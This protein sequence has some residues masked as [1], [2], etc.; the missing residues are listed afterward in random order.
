VWGG[1]M[2]DVA[3]TYSIYSDRASV[4]GAS[5]GVYDIDSNL[6]GLTYSFLY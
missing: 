5:P 6:I 2:L 4:S 1:H 3:Y